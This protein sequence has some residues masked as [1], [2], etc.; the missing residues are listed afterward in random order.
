MAI[1]AIANSGPQPPTLASLLQ[2]NRV[3]PITGRDSEDAKEVSGALVPKAGAKPALVPKLVQ[4]VLKTLSQM[5]ASLS[6]NK[7]EVVAGSSAQAQDIKKTAIDFLTSVISAV[8]PPA[9][10]Q[11]S[12][13]ASPLEQLSDGIS[14]MITEVSS[15]LSIDAAVAQ[16]A[17]KL[18]KASGLSSN[19]NTLGGLLQGLQKSLLD[20]TGAGSLVNVTA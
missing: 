5:G 4:D 13:A 12:K 9:D 20:E 19:A 14:K 18:L 16:S 15:G 7:A 1:S 2:I 3:N 8:K 10:G 6:G 11:T 17:D